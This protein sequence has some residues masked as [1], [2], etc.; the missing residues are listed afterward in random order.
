MFTISLQTKD[1][2]SGNLQKLI[3][4]LSANQGVLMGKISKEIAVRLQKKFRSNGGERWWSAAANSIYK[5]HT[6]TTASVAV[7]QTGVALQRYG[8]T[9]LPKRAKRLAIPL[10]RQF[11]GVNP[12]EI[13]GKKLFALG[14][15]RALGKAYLAY[16]DGGAI[17]V[18][19]LLTPKAVV[20][21][22]P[23]KFLSDE[24]IVSA[25]KEIIHLY[26]NKLYGLSI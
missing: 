24:Q 11:K 8:G 7:K 3:T 9:V 2:V 6:A 26:T 23:D 18:A 12:R 22:H 1:G 5:S 17:R 21:P 13:S 19:Y 25:S 4:G 15:R 14:A 20:K 16:N 10:Q